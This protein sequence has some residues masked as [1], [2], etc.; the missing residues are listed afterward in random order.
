MPHQYFV[1]HAQ[2]DARPW[3]I[4]DETGRVIFTFVRLDQSFMY[5]V[6]D[7]LNHPE[8]IEAD[9]VDALVA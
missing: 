1:D 4:V 2:G 8:L 9:N 6:L 5:E 7:R 3:V